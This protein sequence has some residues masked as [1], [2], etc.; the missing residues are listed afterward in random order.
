MS[1]MAVMDLG[2]IANCPAESSV[3]ENQLLVAWRE[4][5][6]ECSTNARHRIRWCLKCLI[7]GFIEVLPSLEVGT[8]EDKPSG[9][10]R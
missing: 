10:N 1:L 9:M 6:M 3:V 5:G 2:G 7:R 8:P 4:D